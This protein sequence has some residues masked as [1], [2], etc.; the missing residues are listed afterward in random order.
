[1]EL[2]SEAVA[3]A[4]SVLPN[5][6]SV[7]PALAMVYSPMQEW[8]NTYELEAGFHYGTIFPGLNKPFL[9]GACLRV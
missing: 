3:A 9:E 8:E 6:S 5:C 2:N 1:M 7:M 4:N